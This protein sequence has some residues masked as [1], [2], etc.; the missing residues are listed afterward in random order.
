MADGLVL[1]RVHVLVLCDAI[2][3]RAGE[4][5][6]FDLR[7]VRTQLRAASFPCCPPQLCVYLQVSGHEGT[8]SGQVVLVR[9]ADEEELM[10]VPIDD[11]QLW[12]PL[13]AIPVGLRIRN[14]E[15]PSP[16]IYWFW[17]I[18][19]Q[20]L[21]AERRFHVLKTPGSSNGQPNP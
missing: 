12:G 11:I 14:C 13:F 9:E 3:E 5:A 7:G 15:F 8:A 1:A 4:E 6:V 16:G 21:V 20:R 17:V 2:D 18:L 19:N 10:A